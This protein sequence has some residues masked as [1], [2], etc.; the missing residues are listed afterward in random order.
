[1]LK[2]R[3]CN[4]VRVNGD[5]DGCGCASSPCMPQAPK[6]PAKTN[7]TLHVSRGSFM[8]TPR[9]RSATWLQAQPLTEA[10]THGRQQPWHPLP[11]TRDLHFPAYRVSSCAVDDPNLLDAPDRIHQVDAWACKNLL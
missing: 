11:S 4:K 7:A 10:H 1:M 6:A 2:S 8:S 3:V 5:G 9:S